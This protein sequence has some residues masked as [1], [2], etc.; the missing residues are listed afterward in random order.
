MAVELFFDEIRGA[1]PG[2]TIVF[3]HGILGRG[4]NLRSIAKRF[5]DAHPTWTAWL[6]DLRGHGR[7]PKG[8]PG[9]S[10]ESAARDVIELAARSSLPVTA[11]AGHSFGGKVALEAARISAAGSLQHVVVIDSPPGAREPLRGNDSALSVIDTIELLPRNLASRTSFVDALIAAGKPRL[12]AEWLAQSVEQTRQ[13]VRFALDLDEIRNLL[14]DYF[15]RDLWMVV[16]SPPAG[17]CVH[18]VIGDRSDSYSPA[19]RERAF[20]LAAANERV[21]VHVLP[22]GHWVHVDDPDG[23]LQV[24][25]EVV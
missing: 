2:R 15:A 22:A 1:N 18:L 6:V 14:L 19:D 5:V 12:L 4:T 24:L 23:L 7:S 13:G 21:T 3:L 10:L 25:V 9:P 16:E 17:V 11:I 20:R 8:S